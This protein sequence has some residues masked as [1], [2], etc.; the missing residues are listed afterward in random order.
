MEPPS[1]KD[2]IYLLLFEPGMAELLY[3]LLTKK[4]YSA[5]LKEKI[6]K[7]SFCFSR[8]TLYWYYFFLLV[9]Q[10]HVCFK[11]KFSVENVSFCESETGIAQC[12]VLLCISI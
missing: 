12:L 5:E 2:Q 9:A 1:K 10:S 4:E 6:L 11:V 8:P 7:V 3:V